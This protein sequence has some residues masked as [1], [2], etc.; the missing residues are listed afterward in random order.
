[1]NSSPTKLLAI[2]SEFNCAFN[3][4]QPQFK[5]TFEDTIHTSIVLAITAIN[6]FQN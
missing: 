1:M 2:D 5:E 6:N 3:D 4:M